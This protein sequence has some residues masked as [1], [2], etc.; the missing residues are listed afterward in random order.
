MINKGDHHVVVATKGDAQTILG[1]CVR[2]P[3]VPHG[4]GVWKKQ[5]GSVYCLDIS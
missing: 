4:L 2:S 3:N 1:M 5:I